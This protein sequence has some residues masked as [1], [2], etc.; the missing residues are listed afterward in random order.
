[1]RAQHAGWLESI[2]VEAEVLPDDPDEQVARTIGRMRELAFEDAGTAF[3]G[4]LARG[5]PAG[6]RE[7][8]EAAFWFVRGLVRFQRDAQMVPDVPFA[9]E[10]IEVLIRPVDLLSMSRPRGDCDDFCMALAALLV[11]QGIGCSFATVAAD[12]RDP[13][14]YS[15]VYVVAHL[16]GGDL[17]LDASHGRRPGWEVRNVYGKR[18]LWRVDRMNAGLGFTASA[19]QQGDPAWLQIVK[20]GLDFVKGRFGTPENTLV[21]LPD[22]TLVTRGSKTMSPTGTPTDVRTDIRTTQESDFMSSAGWILAAGA[23]M[24]FLV[25]IVMAS[26][27]AKR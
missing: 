21:R 2:N 1:M 19:A 11:A 14:R 18:R 8:A 13:S 16:D 26:K 23:V 25:V 24:V 12:P 7:G 17:S 6:K 4:D 22:G 10:I 3:I 9:E 27:G 15:H 5:F 20:G